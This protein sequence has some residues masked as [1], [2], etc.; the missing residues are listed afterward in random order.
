MDYR[1]EELSAFKRNK[2]VLM[3]CYFEEGPV[4]VKPSAPRQRIASF[5]VKTLLN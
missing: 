3:R 1:G 5:P 4:T 2:E